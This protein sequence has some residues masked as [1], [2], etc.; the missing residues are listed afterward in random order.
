MTTPND[1]TG[2]KRPLSEAQIE[3][4]RA[5]G[6]AVGVDDQMLLDVLGPV[7]ARSYLVIRR[8]NWQLFPPVR[9]LTS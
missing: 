4:R 7:L 3:Q 8:G 9:K 5:A 1:R 2:Q 6:S